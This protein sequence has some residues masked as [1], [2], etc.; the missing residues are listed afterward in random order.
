MLFA[1]STNRYNKARNE[2]RATT[3]AFIYPRTSARQVNATAL[4]GK[5][6]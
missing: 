6:F 2:K 1:V 5:H 3:G 4:A